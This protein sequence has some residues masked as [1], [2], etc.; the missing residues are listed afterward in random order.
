MDARPLHYSFRYGA[1]KG[2]RNKVY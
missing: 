1:A 2:Q